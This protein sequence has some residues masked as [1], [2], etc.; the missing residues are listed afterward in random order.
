M[1]IRV[2]ETSI[3]LFK[4]GSFD[5]IDLRLFIC[6]ML[7]GPALDGRNRV[8]YIQYVKG[9]GALTASIATQGRRM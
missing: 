1:G 8:V 7:S 2:P 9:L 3:F 5:V 6:V 4:G